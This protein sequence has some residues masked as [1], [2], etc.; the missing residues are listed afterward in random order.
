MTFDSDGDLPVTG[1]GAASAADLGV[2]KVGARNS[3]SD[4][5]RI[6]S[7]HDLAVL[8]G[9]VCEHSEMVEKRLRSLYVS[10]PLLNKSE[11]TA[12]AKSQGFPTVQDKLHVTIGYSKV[13]TE[14]P[15]PL[16][17]T[18][19][20]D[21][22]DGRVVTTLGDGGAVVLKF[23][24]AALNARWDQLRASGLSWEH[25]AYTPHVT[26][27]WQA[28]DVNLADVAPFK[29]ELIF[30]PERFAEVDEDWKASATEKMIARVAKVDTELGVVFGW[31]IISKLNGEDYWDTQQDQIPEES[32]LVAS[33][34]Y[35]KGPRI[36]GN[37]HRYLGDTAESVE[38]VGKV[39]FGFP[40]TTEIAKSMGIRC[41]KSGLMIGMKVD[42][43][44]VLRKYQTGEYTG[45][46]IGGYRLVDEVVG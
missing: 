16:R 42:R 9:A 33:F 27:S 46:S 19:V 29:G 14:W 24:S 12:W 8:N 38:P 39:I 17:D 31:A 36:A 35:M 40:L 41:N 1:G 3:R 15:E 26:I 13:P 22:P 45:F 44:D 2:E 37:M 43:P 30:G 6:Q 11:F 4:L 18:L 23:K 7:I 34:D 20:A 28:G 21:D 25:F 32:M 5:A 10:R